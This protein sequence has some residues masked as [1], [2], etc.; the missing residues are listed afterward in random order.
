MDSDGFLV[1]TGLGG[2]AAVAAAEPAGSG[3]AG[4]A[5]SFSAGALPPMDERRRMHEQ[6]CRRPIAD[7]AANLRCR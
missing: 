1:S 4:G 5:S 6:D 2:F 3:I 7:E